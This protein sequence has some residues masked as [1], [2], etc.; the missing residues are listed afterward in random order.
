MKKLRELRKL[1]KMTLAQMAEKTALS[2][3]YLSD[4]E[5]GRAQ[6]SLRTLTLLAKCFDLHP[7]HLLEEQEAMQD[8]QHGDSVESWTIHEVRIVC[9]KCRH[10]L[11]KNRQSLIQLYPIILCLCGQAFH[12]TWTDAMKEAIVTIHTYIDIDC[13]E[14]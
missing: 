4:L 10:M 1:R 9:P 14:D 6:P 13:L 8:L 7:G 5:H 3:S 11:S 2:V 12:I